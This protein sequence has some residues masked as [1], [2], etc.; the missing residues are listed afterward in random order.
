MKLLLACLSPLLLLGCDTAQS[1]LVTQ[2]MTID[3]TSE[4][5]GMFKSDESK[6]NF[7]VLEGFAPHSTGAD[8]AYF[9]FNNQRFVAN[10]NNGVDIISRSFPL[11]ERI[12]LAQRAVEIHPGCAWLGF[13]PAYHDIHSSEFLS[14]G[15][16]SDVDRILFAQVRC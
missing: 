4:N 11:Q 3:I 14:S 1:E 6:I 10:G 5:A 9:T 2:N 12:D 7:M 15:M 8:I 16:T 13:D